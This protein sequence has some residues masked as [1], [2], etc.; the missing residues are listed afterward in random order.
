MKESTQG[1]IEKAGVAKLSYQIRKLVLC[2]LLLTLQIAFSNTTHT[3]NNNPPENPPVEKHRIWINFSGETTGLNQLLLGYLTNATN[4]FDFGIDSK[5]FGWN[6]SALYSLIENDEFNYVI[7]GRALPFDEYDV[8]RLGL[9]VLVS[10]TF[11]ISIADVD[12]I[13][14]GN[15][16]IFLN[17]NLTQTQHN[18][19]QGDY[20][21]ESAAGIYHERFEIVYRPSPCYYST[22]IGSTDTDW[23]TPSNW[24]NATIP[25]VNSKVVINSE[26]P[27]IIN[28]DVAVHSIAITANSSLIVN[29]SLTVGNI[30][31]DEGGLLTIANN[32]NLFQ[33]ETAVNT[34]N[35]KVLRN[36]SLIKH[37][38]YTIWSSPV[39]GQGL[40]AFSPLTLAHRIYAYNAISDVWIQATGNFTPGIGYMFRAPNDFIT[41]PY[42]YNGEFKGIPNNGNITASFSQTGQYQGIGNPYP[43]NL[44]I[45]ELWMS[46]SGVG[47][48]Y[49]WTNTNPWNGQDAYTANNWATYSFM[50]GATAAGG[51][52]TPIAFIPVGQ[53]F[54]AETIPILNSI[55]FTNAMRTTDSG[56]F[57][58]N[59]AEDKYRLWLNLSNATNALNQILIGYMD[60]ATDGQDFRIDAEMFNYNGSA[61]YSLIENST[62]KYTIQGRALPFDDFDV[63]PLGFRAM[64]SGAFTISLS[65]FDGVFAQGQ[66]IFLKDNLTQTEH[67]LKDGDY[68]FVSNQG[69]FATRFEVVYRSSMDVT[70][71]ELDTAWVVYAKDKKF[72]IET[73]GIDLKQVVV[74]D[75]LGRLIYQSQAEGN[76]HSFTK[77]SANQV[78]VIKVMTT[79]GQE[80]TKKVAN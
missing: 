54:V 15:Q 6:G 61:L 63:V 42:S 59:A 66:D 78:L 5:M 47:T 46:N 11:S 17:D 38:D 39:V 40:Q 60:G 16:D 71:P 35:I 22:W 18:L 69:E 2:I 3:M 33:T 13:F 41:T 68:S 74:Y 75:M 44:D 53:G 4:G 9:K 12:S 49:F 7:Q 14:A 51:I 76:T 37:L 50:G 25:T 72:F 28:S 43:S 30:R 29:G 20:T 27:V 77:T 57:F 58:R 45:E 79:A 24:C 67:N 1:H 65:N 55:V 36:S 80:L 21:F 26:N 70:T 19:K 8:V 56:V 62:S 23:N 73:Q 34:G 48:L 32:A 10:G 64:T 52:Q 31:V